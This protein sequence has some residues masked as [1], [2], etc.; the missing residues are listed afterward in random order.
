[1]SYNNFLGTLAAEKARTGKIRKPN[2]NNPI[3]KQKR[4]L[5][6]RINS[7]ASELGRTPED[8]SLEYVVQE[9]P[10]IQRYIVSKGEQPLANP[11]E[12]SVQAF[13]LRQ[14]DISDVVRTLG[15]SRKDA[16][17]YIDEAESDTAE[18]NSSE[19]DNFLGGILTAVG[20]VASNGLNKI[21]AKKEAKGKKPGVWKFL[22][23]LV[24]P[25]G[26]VQAPA[27]EQKGDI[28]G[29]IKIFANDVLD[30]IK[31]QEKQKEIKKM[32][33]MIII[34]VV[35]L[36]LLVVLITKHASKNK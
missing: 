25:A 6:E 8:I 21:V 32:L 3:S 31:K 23:D 12:M 30:N 13:K 29:G 11:V 7:R 36:I 28:L 5:K 20:N 33:P 10:D 2:P 17:A 24:Q 35:V 26:M 14:D 34:G 4:L 22:A 1:M 19:A 9:T 18:L 16:E 15:C 27:L